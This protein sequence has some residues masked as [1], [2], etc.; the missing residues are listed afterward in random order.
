MVGP[1]SAG[2]RSGAGLLRPRWP[3]DDHRRE[4]AAG[5]NSRRPF[6]VSARSRAAASRD[7]AKS[8][9]ARVS[10]GHAIES[11]GSA[12][13]RLSE[14]RGDAHGRS[15]SHGQHGRGNRCSRQWPWSD[16][17]APPANT[18]A[19]S[20]STLGM[21]RI[22]DHPDAGMLSALGMGLADVGRVVTP[23]CLSTLANF[24][25][26]SIEAIADELKTRSRPSCLRRTG[27]QPTNRLSNR[28]RSAIPG[29]RITADGAAGAKSELWPN[30]FISRTNT[31]L[32]TANRTAACELVASAAK[33][34][35][36]RVPSPIHRRTDPIAPVGTRPRLRV[37]TT[38]IWHDSQWI[39]AALIDRS[40]LVWPADRCAG[41]D[42]RRS[43]DTGRRTWL[44]GNG[45]R[46]R[47]HS[48][49]P[50]P[51]ARRSCIARRD[52]YRRGH[53]CR[54]RS[55]VCWK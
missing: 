34:L 23:W 44:A 7:C 25:D 27:G 30:D 4:F 26:E 43:L 14:D 13:R 15:G 55:G 40:S 10:T 52:R 46:R 37:E 8:S 47:H 9:I 17:A 18:C 12:R 41:N 42:R 39:E 24:P 1:D 53:R 3:A 50:C 48:M 36:R 32:A 45:D 38:R 16:S 2:S 33:R 29:N 35:C 28:M 51:I 54:A 31:P 49:L 11:V 6:S 21:R 22:L 19:V 5:A 20:P